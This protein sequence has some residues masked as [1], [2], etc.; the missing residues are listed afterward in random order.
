MGTFYIQ[1]VRH[2]EN[3]VILA[4]RTMKNTFE[5]KEVVKMINSGDTFFVLN[6]NGPRVGV[7][8]EKFIRSYKDGKWTN[9]LDELPEF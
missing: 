3:D 2:D 8:A 9:N 5:T 1:R 4:V 6:E 7:Y